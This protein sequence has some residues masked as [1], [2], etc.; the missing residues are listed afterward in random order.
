MTENALHDMLIRTVEIV[1]LSDISLDP[2]P[3]TM[4]FGYDPTPL[5]HSLLNSGMVNSP[6]VRQEIN[7][8]ATI[9]AGFRRIHA[10]GSLGWKTVPCRIVSRS[11]VGDLKAL[12][13]N[14]HD[15]LTLRTLNEVEKGMVLSRLATHLDEEE[16]LSRFMPILGMASHYPLYR[17]YLQME[18][19]LSVEEKEYVA[20][21]SVSPTAL[22]A[23]FAL[24]PPSRIVL[25]RMIHD[26]GLN[27]NQQSQFI[28]YLI[29]LSNLTH[30]D[31]VEILLDGPLADLFAETSMNRPQKAKAILN[32]LRTIRFPALSRAEQGFKT[33]VSRLHL[34]KGV[35]I[36]HSPYFEGPELKMEIRFTDGRDL[37]KKVDHLTRIET[38][39]TIGPPWE[40]GRH[41]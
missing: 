21:G 3:A 32:H 19:G 29:D 14:L 34:P 36:E 7:A 40:E 11:E 37:K 30:R 25:L 16:I 35:R 27:I 13:I 28:D 20:V 6:I 26:L 9:I 18:E 39:E 22:K 10:A 1:S 33:S 2:G 15:N 17:L 8:K 24:E 5:L 31:I 12:I 38:L 41:D 4:S 23:A